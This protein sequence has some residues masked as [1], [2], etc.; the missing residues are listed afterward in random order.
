MKKNTT[1]QPKYNSLEPSSLDWQEICKEIKNKNCIYGTAV[2]VYALPINDGV[3]F[4]EDGEKRGGGNSNRS[5]S[6]SLSKSAK[7]PILKC[8]MKMAE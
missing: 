3:F 7:Q 5:N 1:V 8:L 2:H 4:E 6:S